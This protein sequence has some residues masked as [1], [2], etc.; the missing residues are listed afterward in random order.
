MGGPAQPSGPTKSQHPQ[1]PPVPA[2]GQPG[3]T[4]T[5]GPH[6]QGCLARLRQPAG[7][8]LEMSGLCRPWPVFE[9]RL[10]PAQLWTP[11]PVTGPVCALVYHL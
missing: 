9:P 1:Q 11:R 8:V 5:Q 6:P 4:C 3:V 7:T 10:W 2:L